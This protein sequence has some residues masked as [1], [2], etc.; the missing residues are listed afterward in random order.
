MAFTSPEQPV[1][2][3]VSLEEILAT[4]KLVDQIHVDDKIRDYIVK[5]V[6]ATRRRIGISG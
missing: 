3:V 4:R 1:Q 6:F 2:P 5:I